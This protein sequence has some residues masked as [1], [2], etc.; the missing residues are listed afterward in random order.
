MAVIGLIVATLFCYFNTNKINLSFKG[1]LV[2]A[3]GGMIG[4]LIC[5]K[6]MFAIA[7]IPS[8]EIFNLS[9]FLNYVVNGGIVFYGGMFGLLLGFLVV[10]KIKKD[11]SV[12]ILNFFAPAIPLFHIFARFG[13]FLSGCCYGIPYK[14]GV[15][16]LHSPE[17]VRFPVQLIECACN[18]I[19]FV[20]IILIKKRHFEYS[21]QLYLMSYA[22][23]RFVLEFFRGD[24]VRGIWFQTFSTA[25]IISII[26]LIISINMLFIR[27]YKKQIGRITK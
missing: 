10:S 1:L 6:T 3:L 8:M 25:Q 9:Q 26:V 24:S 21:L 5:S 15:Y 18:I 27:L 20:L 16:M 13:C 17:I 11:S 22:A 4:L 23:C 14:W 12:T 19:I 2:Y 7:M